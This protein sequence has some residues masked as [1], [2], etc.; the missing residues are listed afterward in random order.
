MTA[1]ECND[2]FDHR[3]VF[4]DGSDAFVPPVAPM[5][6]AAVERGEAV[7]VTV[8]DEKWRALAA[9][10]GSSAAGV[11]R[12]DPADRYARPVL[13]LQRLQQFVGDALSTGA[14]AVCVIGQL[15]FEGLVPADEWLRYEAAATEAFRH[16]PTRLVCLYDTTSVAS[17]V[18]DGARDVHPPVERSD[19]RPSLTVPVLDRAALLPSQRPPDL[20]V[21]PLRSVASARR[22]MRTAFDG[23]IPADLLEDIVLVVSE[24]ASN[25]L[26][27]GR[28]PV[29]VAAWFGS[30]LVDVEVTDTGDGPADPYAGLRLPTDDAGGFGLWICGHVADALLCGTT[31]DGWTA[32]ATF[33]RR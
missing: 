10:L 28:Q 30:R 16:L 9:S 11:T 29:T 23:V 27:H 18:L 33:R 12:S 19:G 1:I 31:P 20:G 15:D 13:A 4:Y 8:A 21:E 6:E 32:R 2:V 24:L 25:A 14:P 22:V 26:R 7:L 5:I 17:P 3:A